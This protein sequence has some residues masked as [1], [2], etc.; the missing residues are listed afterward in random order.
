LT[1]STTPPVRWDQHKVQ[2]LVRGDARFLASKS[3]TAGQGAD[4]SHADSEE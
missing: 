3:S 1:S 4:A 2:M